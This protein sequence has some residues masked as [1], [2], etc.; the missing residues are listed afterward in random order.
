MSPKKGSDPTAAYTGFEAESAPALRQTVYHRDNPELRC[1]TLPADLFF[2]PSVTD[3]Y[4]HF[5]CSGCPISGQC[6]ELALR[7]ESEYNVEGIRGGR[8]PRERRAML[9]LRKNT[10]GS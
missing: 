6:L 2:R 10:A 7:E 1:R 3:H 4:A 8:S 9:R 5:L